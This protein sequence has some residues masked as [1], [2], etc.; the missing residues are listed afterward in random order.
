MVTG[1][2]I[3]ILK[4]FFNHI[5]FILCGQTHICTCLLWHEYEDFNVVLSLRHGLWGPSSGHG[6]CV[7]RAFPLTI[8]VMVCTRE[9]GEAREH[10]PGGRLMQG[11]RLEVS[12]GYAVI[13]VY[14]TQV[15]NDQQILKKKKWS[16]SFFFLKKKERKRRKGKMGMC[17]ISVTSYSR[18]G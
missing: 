14:K 16:H 18:R 2:S 3:C 17:V 13:S 5:L 9:A 6:V 11:C 8:C 1:F 7:A 10:G 4:H 12:L 15:C